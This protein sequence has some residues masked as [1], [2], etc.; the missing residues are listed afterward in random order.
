M[1]K[2]SSM[3]YSDEQK[4]ITALRAGDDLAFCEIIKRFQHTMLIVA[5]A[6]SGDTFADDVVQ[7]AWV[8][9]YKNISNFEQRSSLC[10]VSNITSSILDC[11]LV[12]D[13]VNVFT[14]QSR[15]FLP[16]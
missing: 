16:Y 12:Y 10:L 7:D 6:I 13:R 9:I 1:A 3:D 15:L 5:R 8:A 2:V 14:I 4:L 11:R